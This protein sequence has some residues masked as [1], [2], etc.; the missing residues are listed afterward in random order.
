MTL[1]QK[2]KSAFSDKEIRGRI[3]FVLF[4]LILFRLLANIPIPGVDAFQLEGFLQSNQFLG[5]LNIFSGGGLSSLSLVMLGVGPFI[6]ASIVM[7]LLT[8]MS[9]KLKTMY[10]EEGAA[11]REKFTQVSR[12]LT[13]PLALIQGFGLM[14]L[15][16]RQGILIDMSVLDKA[17]NLIVIAAGSLILTW[18]GELISEKGVGN[19]VSILIFAGIISALPSSIQQFAF[20]FDKAQ[21][22][23]YIAFVAVALLIIYGVI[24]ITEAERPVP[25]TYARAGVAGGGVSSFLPLRVNQAGVM[26]IIFALS[27][28]MFP[29]VLITLLAEVSTPWIV[30]AINGISWFLQSTWAYAAAYFI[31]V[32]LF[33]Y[34]YTAITF[35]PEATAE[36]LQKSGAFVPGVRPGLQTTEYIGTL[37]SRIT[38]MGALFLGGIAVLPIIMQ[39]VTGMQSLAI[40]GTALLIVVS[41]VL[42]IIKKLDGAVAM[43]Q[44]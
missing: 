38:F 31:L 19:G 41:V 39:Q 30:S 29:Q 21:L 20:I 12:V 18:I 11:G 25:I 1:W 44:Y 36:N 10:H 34:F 13:V 23:L 6:T 24:M 26:P 27:I 14:I 35:D 32:V 15:L 40:G 37:V 2:I 4:T 9:P 5:L 17:V 43:R 3:F 7:Q 33:T 8:V 42:D 16:E 28:L 22:P